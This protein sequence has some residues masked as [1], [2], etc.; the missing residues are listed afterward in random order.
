MKRNAVEMVW[1]FFPLSFSKF[2]IVNDETNA[3]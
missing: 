3:L 1:V 2:C